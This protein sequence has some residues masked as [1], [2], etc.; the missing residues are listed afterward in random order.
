MLVCF[1]SLP[2]AW[3]YTF[4]NF[5]IYSRTQII[6]GVIHEKG[7]VEEPQTQKV[8]GC[9][10]FVFPFDY[11]FKNLNRARSLFEMIHD[12]TNINFISFHDSYHSGNTV[13]I[14][15]SWSNSLIGWTMPQRHKLYHWAPAFNFFR[16]RGELYYSFFSSLEF[17]NSLTMT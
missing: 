2:V 6:Y 10:V 11:S 15:C 14:N 8:T 13:H 7:L 1:A 12:F 3:F 9:F 5:T 16:E 17:W 4:S